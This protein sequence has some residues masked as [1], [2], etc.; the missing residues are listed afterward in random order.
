M[1]ISKIIVFGVLGICLLSYAAVSFI[2]MKNTIELYKSFDRRIAALEKL[3][4][5]NK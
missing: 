1:E 2:S 4:E 3:S 5:T